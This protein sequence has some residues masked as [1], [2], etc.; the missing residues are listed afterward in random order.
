[1]KSGKEIKEK[2]VPGKPFL[3][4]ADR[5][6]LVSGITEKELIRLLPADERGYAVR[7]S[8]PRAL[9]RYVTGRALLRLVIFDCTGTFPSG[10]L[11][12]DGPAGAPVKIHTK[13]GNDL[14]F[15]MS[16]SK[17][18]TLIG[19]SGGKRIGVDI[20]AVRPVKD[21]YKLS[22]YAFSEAEHSW[23][24]QL[25]PN[26][27]KEAFIR[28]WTRKEAIVKYHTGTIAGDMHKFTVPLVFEAGSYTITP[29][30][31][32]ET[33]S[34]KLYDLELPGKTY[35][36]LCWQGSDTKIEIIHTDTGSI[37]RMLDNRRILDLK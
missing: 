6:E 4:L 37:R 22:S 10:A 2:F 17:D 19:I 30:L 15:S 25:P 13:H 23:L 27:V 24:T 29:G 34:L 33:A 20:E 7:F 36:A 28:I 26:L 31:R 18:M 1:M 14:F 8:H 5:N 9:R 32:G 35:G 11:F 16:H 3:F 21:I 12:A